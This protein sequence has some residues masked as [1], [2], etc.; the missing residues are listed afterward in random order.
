PQ[1]GSGGSI[2]ANSG[3]TLSASNLAITGGSTP[4]GVGGCIYSNSTLFSLSD[5][6]VAN[7]QAVGNGGAIDNN[8]GTMTLT[9]TSVTG[10]TAIQGGGILNFATLNI[11]SSTIS[12]NT[13][14][15]PPNA[16]SAPVGGGIYNL[17][18]LSFANS[19]LSNNSAQFGGGLYNVPGTL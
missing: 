3:T 8:A 11:D 5:S 19:T 7:C 12:G 15:R 13:A 18:N 4:E 2:L 10:S 6:S 9:R 1:E 14:T 16:G 17:G